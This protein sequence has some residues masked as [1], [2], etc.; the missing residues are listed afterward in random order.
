MKTFSIQTPKGQRVIGQGQPCFI[1][2]EMSGN[3][4]HSYDKAVEIA[5]GVVAGV[6]AVEFCG[7][8]NPVTRANVK[9]R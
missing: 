4:H 3:H 5:E 6:C 7:I 2:A 9:K 1:I 8:Q